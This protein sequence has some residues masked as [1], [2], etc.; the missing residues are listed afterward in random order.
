MT[1]PMD[2]E[3]EVE[4]DVGD[5]RAGLCKC[6][7]NPNCPIHE[8]TLTLEE[9]MENIEAKLPTMIRALGDLAIAVDD[10]PKSEA[11]DADRD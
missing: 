2:E 4:D 8:G 9:A 6:R 11:D 7:V 3:G 1:A 10:F 5:V